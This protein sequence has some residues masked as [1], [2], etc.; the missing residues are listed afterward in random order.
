[1]P[2][3]FRCQA[4][5]KLVR[6]PEQSGGKHGKCPYCNISVFIPTPPEESDEIGLTPV[7]E[8]AAAHREQLRKESTD[9][10]ASVDQDEVPKYDLH[11]SSKAGVS[12]KPGRLNDTSLGRDAAA[13]VAVEVN[14]FVRAMHKSKL[15]VADRI[16]TRLKQRKSQSK[17]YVQGL[18]V[19]QTGAAVEDIPPALVQGFLKT[20][21][22]RLD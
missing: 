10:A 9:Y 18:M 6:A 1:M 8:E 14:K 2:I 5:G 7:N 12:S 11:A 16:T 22:E 19:D 17:D 15:D 4:C 21:L 20:L 3:E 13:D